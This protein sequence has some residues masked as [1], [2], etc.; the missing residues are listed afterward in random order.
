MHYDP[1][2]VVNFKSQLNSTASSP[3]CETTTSESQCSG[4]SC[5]PSRLA[6]PAPFRLRTRLGS[7]SRRPPAVQTRCRSLSTN[8]AAVNEVKV[9]S[10]PLG[11]FFFLRG[12]G[13]MGGGCMGRVCLGT[14]DS[15]RWL[16]IAVRPLI[17]SYSSWHRGWTRCAR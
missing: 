5:R 14:I 12:G 15:W 16:F 7:T 10:S 2:V 9:S 1:S 4:G 8:T 6:R 3:K 17:I 13:V 11:F